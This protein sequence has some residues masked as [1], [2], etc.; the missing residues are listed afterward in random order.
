MGLW[1]II[2]SSPNEDKK[3]EKNLTYQKMAGGDRTK[4]WQSLDL[5]Q[6]GIYCSLALLT[7][8][9]MFSLVRGWDLSSLLSTIPIMLS[10]SLELV[11][12]CLSIIYHCMDILLN[13]CV[14]PSIF[15]SI[16]NCFKNFQLLSFA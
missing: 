13:L 12:V 8:V 1:E 15:L 14:K 4:N 7:H 2:G 5:Y 9:D 6:K 3:R 10:F 16:F 11:L